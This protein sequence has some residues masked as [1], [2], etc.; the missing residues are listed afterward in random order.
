MSLPILYS[1]RRCPYAMR[2]RMALAKAKIQYEIREVDLKNKPAALL[3]ASPK[4]TVPVLILPND[5]IE[6]SLE[7]MHWAQCQAAGWLKC[8]TQNAS[9][10]EQLIQQNDT[11]F[12]PLLD[13]YKYPDRITDDRPRG[14]AARKQAEIIFLQPLE[15]RL[16]QT[17]FLLGDEVALADLAIFPFIR[18]FAHVDQSWFEQAPY[19]QLQQWLAFFLQSE[20]FKT[21][22]QPYAVWAPQATECIV[23]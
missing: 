18:Q 14:E 3:T 21:I 17:R 7:I 4:G 20:L 1:F 5:I 6:E 10:A 9:Q 11:V 2:A 22:M 15:K 8:P 12:K 23:N 16:Q 19:P 13:G